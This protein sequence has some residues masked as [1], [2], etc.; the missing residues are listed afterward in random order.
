MTGTSAGSAY[1]E[2]IRPLAV[3]C[4]GCACTSPWHVWHR[5]SNARARWSPARRSCR[6]CRC[7]ASLPQT[8]QRPQERD[9]TMSRAV[10]P[11][12]SFVPGERRTGPAARSSAVRRRGADRFMAH[13]SLTSRSAAQPRHGSINRCCGQVEA[14]RLK[15][16][17]GSKDGSGAIR[18]TPYPLSSAPRDAPGCTP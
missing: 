11:T 5:F 17:D 10:R 18:C 12:G 6:W 3:D 1:W 14:P 16:L 2:T 15:V 4:A 7:T 8:S 13:H 9:R